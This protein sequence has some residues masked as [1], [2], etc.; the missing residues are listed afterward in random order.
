MVHLLLGCRSANTD[1]SLVKQEFPVV[2]HVSN[3]TS[4]VDPVDIKISIDNDKPI[5]NQNFSCGT[6]HNVSTFKLAFNEGVHQLFVTSH[7]GDA[8]LDFVFMLDK[9]VWLII[10]YWGKNHFQLNISYKPVVFI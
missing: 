5:V 6:G 3:Q 2:L 7:N 4:E 8:G 10:H 1:R 9:P